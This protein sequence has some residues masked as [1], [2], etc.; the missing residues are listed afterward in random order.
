MNRSSQ[1]L[2]AIVST[3]GLA[4]GGLAGG[5]LLASPA[6]ATACAGQVRYASSSNTLY[7]TSGTAS[8]SAMSAL[9]PAAPLKQSLPGVWELSADLVI[10]NGAELDLHGTSIGGDVNQLRLRS[11]ESTVSTDVSSITAQTGT[12]DIRNTAI[13]SWND[14]TGTPDTNPFLP[15]GAP[16]TARGRAWIRAISTQDPDGTDHESTM[17]IVN[18]DLG[19][20]GYYA[21]ESYGVAYK[22]RG[23]DINHQTVCNSL[24]V[25]GEEL[26]SHFHNNFMGTYTFDAYGMTFDHSEYDHNYMYGLDPHDDSDFLTITNNHFHDNGDHGLICSQRCDHLTITGN[27]SDHNGIPPY[28]GPTD[29]DTSDDQIHGIMLHR[30]VTD[31][32]IANNY[33]HDNPTGAGIAL[34]DSYNDTITNNTITGNKYGLRVSVGSHDDTFTNNTITNSSAYGIYTYQGTDTPI[35]GTPSGRPAALTFANDPINASGSNAIKLTSSDGMI[36]TNV[37]ITNALDDV[38]V[39]QSSATLTGVSLGGRAVDVRG[40]AGTPGSATVVSPAAPFVTS[41]D[42]FSSLDVTSPGG[43]LSRAGVSAAIASTVTPTGST[44]HLTST[45]IGTS[46]VTVTPYPAFALPATGSITA[47]PSISGT[48]G[49]PSVV[50]HIVAKGPSSAVFVAYAIGGLTPGKSYPVTK[51]GALLTTQ[52]AGSDGYLHFTTTTGSTQV[53]YAV[54]GV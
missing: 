54:A 50:H 35:Y 39:D 38:R 25:Y 9:C 23:C 8:L 29:G 40:I 6:A 31:T 5:L 14:A 13:T 16:A 21:G 27:E 30:G 48:A 3:A 47:T 15:A 37:A 11:L 18:S 44:L 45:L 43:Q 33:V 51:N 53:D 22:A 12:I 32:V 34:F 20:L 24:N 4:L 42:A 41:L 46:N 49:T 1:R 19:Y 10:Q 7:L 26:G 2:L 17:N 52:T 36:V 28:Q